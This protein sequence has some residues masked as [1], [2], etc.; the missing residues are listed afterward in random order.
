MPAT[1]QNQWSGKKIEPLYRPDQADLISVKLAAS[2]NFPRG[3]ILAEVTATP[4]T[5]GVYADAGAGGLGVARGILA[6]DVQTDAAGL[7]TYSSTASQVGGEHGQQSVSTP[8]YVRGFFD[9]A[10]LVGLDAA[11]L[12]DMSGR[13]VYGDITAG[14]IGIGV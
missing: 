7:I 9:P 5:F 11:A 1:F 14:C 10:E 4:G 3:T 6:Y 13:I 12:A 2:T 8:M